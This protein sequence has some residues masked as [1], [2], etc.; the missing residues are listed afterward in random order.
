MNDRIPLPEDGKCPCG[1][2]DLVLARD[3]TQYTLYVKDPEYGWQDSGSHTEE[4][5]NDDPLG[6][7]RLFC[8]C[9]GQYFFVPDELTE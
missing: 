5:C 8:T 1:C 3:L 4:L 2:S 6:D 7:V 9:C